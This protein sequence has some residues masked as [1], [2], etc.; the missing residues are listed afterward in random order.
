M[1]VPMTDNQL[2]MMIA[3]MRGITDSDQKMN[4]LRSWARAKLTKLWE[5]ELRLVFEATREEE[6]AVPTHTYEQVVESTELTLLKLDIKVTREGEVAVPAHTHE[7]VVESTELTIP[8]LDQVWPG[9]SGKAKKQ[10]AVPTRT[11]A[12][13]EEEDGSADPHL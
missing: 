4:L 8:K 9:T 3:T 11:E 5:K 2:Q 10:V 6:A 13:R 12:T 7:R 1:T